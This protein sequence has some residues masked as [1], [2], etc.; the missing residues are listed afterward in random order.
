MSTDSDTPDLDE[1]RDETNN[2]VSKSQT[3]KLIG[4]L[5]SI[6]YIIILVFGYFGLSGFVLFLCKMAQANIFPTD[7]YCYPYNETKYN[8]SPNPVQTYIFEYDNGSKNNSTMAQLFEINHIG[9]NGQY[10]LLNY[11][12]KCKQSAKTGFL[13]NYFISIVEELMAFN[14][15]IISNTM[16]LLN[17][18]SESVIVLLGPLY[19]GFV[20]TFA[21]L[22]N[23]VYLIY[24][25][26]SK[27]SWFFKKIENDEWTDVSI[28]EPMD[29]GFA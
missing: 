24:L 22:L 15:T 13:G 18:T 21:F 23:Q 10:K 11:F 14:Y 7:T 9:K 5:H 27:M 29:Y 28:S 20:L 3:E 1:K 19:A 25:W 12:L 26:F 4:F 2:T 17:G 16:N 6:I 8:I